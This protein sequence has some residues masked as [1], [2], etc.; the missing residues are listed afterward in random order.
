M[1]QERRLMF[2]FLAAA[3]KHG[4]REGTLM[5]PYDGTI[6]YLKT[7]HSQLMR[8]NRYDLSL[9]AKQ[10]FRRIETDKVVNKLWKELKAEIA[11]AKKE[12]QAPVSNTGVTPP[13]FAALEDYV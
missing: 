11:E 12:H 2:A 9:I 13:D 1:K 6:Y 8:D 10:V 4:T 7:L 3:V 5:N